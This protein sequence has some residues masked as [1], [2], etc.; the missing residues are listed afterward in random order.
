MPQSSGT[1]FGLVARDPSRLIYAA[2]DA[3]KQT[4]TPTYGTGPENAP[5]GAGF[6]F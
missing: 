4:S 5:L 1:L 6:R 2:R 3:A